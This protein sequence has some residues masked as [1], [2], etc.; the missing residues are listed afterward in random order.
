M[1]DIYTHIM[2][3]RF[4][5]ELTKTSPKLGNIGARMRNVK[6]IHDLDVRFRLMDGAGA[7]YAQVIS[8]P[9]PPLED[10]CGPED[11]RRLAAI[12]NDGM[13][14]LCAKH[15]DRFPAFAASISMLDMDGAL[16]E[17][18]R[19]VTQL[20]RAASRFS[21]MSPAS[22]SICQSTSRCSRPWRATACRSGCILRARPT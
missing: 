7:D 10:V 20:A 13:A 1:I 19:A 6:P 18:E 16:A 21:R 9:N 2:P 17:I 15:P 4:F 22:R 11:A 14:E 12:G 3:S 8:L 5:D